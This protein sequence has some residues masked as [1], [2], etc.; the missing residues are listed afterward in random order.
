MRRK[1]GVGSG[2]NEDAGVERAVLCL[3]LF[4]AEGDEAQRKNRRACTE[5]FP[6]GLAK[7]PA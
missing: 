2:G 3:Q 6:V 1:I 5:S 7:V 4:L